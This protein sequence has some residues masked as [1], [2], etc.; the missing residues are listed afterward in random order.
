[1]PAP[2]LVAAAPAALLGLVCALTAC[3]AGNQ[4]PSPEPTTAGTPLTAYDVGG[5]VLERAGFCDRIAA[6]GVVA[7]LDGSAAEA[8]TWSNGDAARLSDSVK[9][10]AHEFG[11]RYT[12]D[13]AAA[14]AWLFAPPVTPD[15]AA[16]LAREARTAEGCAEATDSP[17]FGRPSV[18]VVCEEP[19]GALTAAHRGL[20]GDSWLACEVTRSDPPARDDLLDAA[21]RWCVSVLEAARAG[22]GRAG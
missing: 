21:G 4:G 12:R 18:A 6:P 8:R 11:C 15:R 9:D 5:V 19:D 7:A 10:V 17:A 1:M 2:R 22:S 3:T 20:F 13:G 16:E 14:Q